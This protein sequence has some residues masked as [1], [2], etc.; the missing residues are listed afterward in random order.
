MLRALGSPRRELRGGGGYQ[1]PFHNIRHLG[2]SPRASQLLLGLQSRFSLV[3]TGLGLRF[4][5]NKT[6]TEQRDRASRRYILFFFSDPTFCSGYSTRTTHTSY[7]TIKW[8]DGNYPP[9]PPPTPSPPRS[10]YTVVSFCTSCT[11]AAPVPFQTR[12]D[13][14]RVMILYA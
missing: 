5:R 2:A 6:I 4:D 13:G 7:A 14:S 9:P 1:M 11:P 8:L 10:Y 3:S 12:N